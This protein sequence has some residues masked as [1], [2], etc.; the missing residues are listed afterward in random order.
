MKAKK[1]EVIPVTGIPIVQRDDDITQLLRNAMKQTGFSLARGDVLIVSHTIVSVAEGTVYEEAMIVPSERACEIA[2]KGF[3]SETRVEVALHEASE[4]IREEPVLVTK[5][6]QGLIT[7]FSGVDESN[8]PEG[9]LIVLPEDPDKSALRIHNSISKMVGFPVPVIITDTQG[10]P[11]REGAVNLAIGLA[12][13]SPFTENKGAL[14]IH[15]KALRSSLVCIAD[16]IAASAELV[17]GQADEK[18]PIAVVRDLDL[19]S[20]S[21]TARE[22]LRPDS[23]NLFR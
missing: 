23:E 20:M 9:T 21:G 11:W 7:D 12:G 13:L 10:R 6:K 14:D 18:V 2:A 15:G 19:K 4:I 8:A 16:E 22:I 1:I 5:T 3:G 17:M